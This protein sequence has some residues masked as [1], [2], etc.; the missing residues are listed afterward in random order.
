MTWAWKGDWIWERAH[1]DD[2]VLERDDLR[3][4]IHRRGE[5]SIWS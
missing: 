2:L 5:A 3:D 4:P 1:Q